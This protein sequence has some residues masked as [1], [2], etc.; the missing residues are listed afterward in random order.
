MKITDCILHCKRASSSSSLR[1]Q[2]W[3]KLKISYRFLGNFSTKN[4]HRVKD[5]PNVQFYH[6]FHRESLYSCLCVFNSVSIT[7]ETLAK[8]NFEGTKVDIDLEPHLLDD[9]LKNLNN[10]LFYTFGGPFNDPSESYVAWRYY[11]H[12]RFRDDNDCCHRISE[13]LDMKST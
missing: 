1:R 10:P 3:A 12:L 7:N 6:I 11:L 2:L 9:P 13:K 5:N 4:L 8:V